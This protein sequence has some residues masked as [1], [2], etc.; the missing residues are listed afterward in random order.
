MLIMD[1]FP[2]FV[3]ITKSYA[4]IEWVI[5]VA[6]ESGMKGLILFSLALIS[7]LLLN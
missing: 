5:L 6:L 3:K 7:I 1:G 4:N 2:P